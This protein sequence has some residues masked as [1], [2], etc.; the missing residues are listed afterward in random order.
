MTSLGNQ[1][2]GENKYEYFLGMAKQEIVKLF[3]HTNCNSSCNSVRALFIMI[4]I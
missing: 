3:T 2:N 4:L 1:I